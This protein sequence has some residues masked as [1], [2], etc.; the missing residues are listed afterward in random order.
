[1]GRIIAIDYGTKRV[2]IAVTDPEQIIAT[3]LQTVHSKDA[4]TF[5]REYMK[6]EPV[7]CFVV[8]EPRKMDNSPSSVTP[9][10]EAFIR[11][12]KRAFPSIPIERIDERFTSKM[13]SQSL[14]M[15]GVKKMERR[16]KELV[17]Q[18]SAVLILQSFME[19]RKSKE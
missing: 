13:A 12:L 19:S 14:I 10:V 3:A 1:M 7:E 2:G 17:D 16:N 5:L 6:T 11:E 15:S 4:M 8:G 18:V 9:Q